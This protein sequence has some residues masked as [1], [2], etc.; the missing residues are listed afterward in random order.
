[1]NDDENDVKDDLDVELEDDGDAGGDAAEPE[2]IVPPEEGIA[3]LKR[4]LEQERALRL[5]AER[6]RV[7]MAR[8]EQQARLDKRDAD[9]QLVSSAAEAL[10]RDIEIMTANQ[11][12]AMQRGDHQAAAKFQREISEAAAQAQQLKNGLRAMEEERKKPVAPIQPAAPVDP[13]E[14]FVSQL[15]TE[16]SKQWVRAHPE[17]ARDPRLTRKMIAAHELAVADGIPPDSPQYF[18]AIERTLNIKQ[19]AA[20]VADDA[21]EGAAKVTQRRDAAPAAAPVSRGTPRNNVVRLSGQER[22]IAEMMG[23]KPEEYAKHKMALQK[24]GK[25]K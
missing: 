7:E 24:E 22:E 12:N 9:Y 4:Q 25:L 15:A 10:E 20:P 8:R 6:D 1:M 13:V 16:P 2:K 14:A 5:Q 19:Q 18:E 11:A 21:S 17:Y 3:E 23:M